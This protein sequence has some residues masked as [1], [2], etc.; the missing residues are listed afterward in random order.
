[1][2]MRLLQKGI[3]VAALIGTLTA[4]SVAQTLFDGFEPPTYAPGILTGQNSWYNPMPDSSTDWSVYLY[5]SNPL[6]IGANPGGATQMIAAVKNTSGFFPRAQKDFAWNQRTA[7]L[8][9]YDV[10]VSFDATFGDNYDNIGSFSLQPSG[11]NQYFIDLFQ[12]VTPTTAEQVGNPNDGWRMTWVVSDSGGSASPIVY[13]EPPNPFHGL[14]INK[15]YRRFVAFD[16][17]GTDHLNRTVPIVVKVGVRDLATGQTWATPVGPTADFPYWYLV[18]AG[19][20]PLPTAFRFFVGGGT[21]ANQGNMLAV[22]NIAF[23][24]F[25]PGDVNMDGCVDD[26]DLLE[27]LLAFG[28]T[29]AF[30]PT[31]VNGDG[32]VDDADLLEVLLAFGSGC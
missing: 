21:G 7:W 16:F 12:W 27:V 2:M 19:G 3:S 30:L 29:G 22:D 24:A 32:T 11:T 15:W 10:Y 28:N 14:Q 1:M 25:S 13:F 18:F 4:S 17:Q 31:D 5:A 6:G 23:T 9:S 26:A 8:V 20:R